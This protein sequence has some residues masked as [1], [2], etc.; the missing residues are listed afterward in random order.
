MVPVASLSDDARR[1]TVTS[2]QVCATVG[3]WAW[4]IGRGLGGQ[5]HMA[6]D[7]LVDE[8]AAVPSH[9]ACRVGQGPCEEHVHI[10][11]N[12]SE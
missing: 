4:E 11:V 8:L 2:L 12:P 10:P 3:T 6:S 5:A 1:L 7:S 9:T